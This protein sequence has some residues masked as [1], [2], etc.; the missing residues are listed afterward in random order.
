MYRKFLPCAVAATAALLPSQTWQQIQPTVSP[1]LRRAGA[2]AFDATANRLI[3][4]GG[5]SPTPAEILGQTWSYNGQ[6]SL[7]NPAGG[8]LPRWGHQLV[9]DTALNRLIT[10]GGRSPTI[11]GLANDTYAWTGSAWTQVPTPTAPSPRFR[12]GLAY[13]SSRNRV[14]LFGGRG[15]TEVYSDTWEF[16]GVAWTERTTATVPPPRED[17]LLAYDAGLARTVLFGG[18]D[19]D[20]DTLLG[21]TWEFDGEDWQLRAVTGGPTARFRAAGVF[22]SVRQRIVMYGGFDGTNLLAETWEYFGGSWIQVAG[23]GTPFATEMYAGYDSQ[24]RKFVTFGGVGDQFSN[25]TWEFTGVATGALG[26]FGEGCPTSAGIAYPT[27]P[28]PPRIN[29]TYTIE[30][31]NLPVT[32]PAVIAVH[33]VSNVQWS[34]IPLPFDLSIIDLAGCSL[35][36]S[37]DLVGVEPAAGGVAVTPLTIPNTPAFVG[38]SIY[39][40]VLIPDPAAFNGVG[41]TSVGARSL[42]G[43]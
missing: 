28:T 22:D 42:L 41:G 4:Y 38:T 9:R 14:V 10:F 13:D 32:T 40:Q 30:W 15:L 11:S 17:M 24:R 3:L 6:W 35:L 27:A 1:S 39:S 5:V 36:V 31:Q 18:Y 21:D 43:Q 26:T 8:S 25:D 19:P 7:L 12:Y 16:D 2:M 20:T 37:A 23:G 33:G 34:G 29:T